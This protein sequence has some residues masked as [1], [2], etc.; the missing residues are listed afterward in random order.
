M[1]DTAKQSFLR[2]LHE[3]VSD[4]QIRSALT[5]FR[6]LLWVKRQNG[7]NSDEYRTAKEAAESAVQA[8]F[9]APTE[10]ADIDQAARVHAYTTFRR[11]AHAK[12]AL[13]PHAQSE[14]V[15]VSSPRA[16]LNEAPGADL[17]LKDDIGDDPPVRV[18]GVGTM[19]VDT[20]KTH[21]QDKLR[22]LLSQVESEAWDHINWRDF[23][24]MTALARSIDA[25][26][27][28]RT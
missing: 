21:L 9:G 8:Y 5:A 10:Y 22:Q 28:E 11:A 18:G 4:E 25:G 16:A 2:I 12:G 20:A 13:A 6:R 1:T 14:A 23:D 19:T 17:G 15:E 7:V 27:K 3:D 26:R 24:Q